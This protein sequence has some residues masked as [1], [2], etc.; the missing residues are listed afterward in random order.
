MPIFTRTIN[1]IGEKN[2]EKLQKS[3]VMIFGCGG[4]GSYAVEAIA[5]AGVGEITV[6]DSKTVGVSNINRQLVAYNSTVGKNKVDVEKERIADINPDCVVNT[7][8]EFFDENSSL[9]LDC[10]YIVDAIDSVPSK[11][12]LVQKA[13]EK[14]IPVISSMGTGNKM[15]PE[16]LEIS[17][18]SKTSVCPLAK[19]MRLE[20]RKKGI[21][22]LKVV[23]SKEIPVVKCIPPASN[24]FVPAA[25]G[26]LLASVVVRDLIE[27]D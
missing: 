7:V 19:K 26:L 18:I 3:H 8:T 25:A 24:S 15:C 16:M 17:D 9:S 1:L 2:F 20:L 22:H 14:G 13:M 5:R 12:F 27:K 21:K 11:I 4:V 6:I 10:D 23:Y